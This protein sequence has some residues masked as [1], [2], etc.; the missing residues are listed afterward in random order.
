MLR[1]LALDPSLEERV[2]ALDPEHVTDHDVRFTLAAAPTPRIILV[3]GSVYPAFLAMTSFASFL[4]GMGYPDAKL[5]D[6]QDGAYSQSPYGRRERLAV[7]IAWYYENDVGCALMIA[8]R[9]G[10][11]TRSST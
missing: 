9:R 5:R 2:L 3:H 10:S 8:T 7:Q 6:P 11:S 4:D 1:S